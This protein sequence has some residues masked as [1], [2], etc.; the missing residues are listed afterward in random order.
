MI[1]KIIQRL[2]Y[3]EVDKTR[4]SVKSTDLKTQVSSLN[5]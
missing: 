3:I 2:N 1:E 4:L 5:V